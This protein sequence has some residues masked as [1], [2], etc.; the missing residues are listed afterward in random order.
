MKKVVML[1]VCAVVLSGLSGCVSLKTVI[2]AKPGVVDLADDAVQKLNISQPVAILNSSN[3]SG[4]IQIGEWDVYG[5]LHE[6]TETAIQISK[7]SLSRQGIK[8]SDS[9]GKVLK[10]RVDNARSE[11]GALFGFKAIIR[12]SVKTGNGLEKTYTGEESHNNGYGTTSALEKSLGQCVQQ[13]L[14]DKDIINYLEK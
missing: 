6:L 9:A 4:D 10:M 12:L 1:C 8:I 3:K 2:R 5:N 7:N 14:N 13:M 11:M